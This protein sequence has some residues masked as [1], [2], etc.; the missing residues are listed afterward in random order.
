[1]L[2]TTPA[3]AGAA[4]AHA[5]QAATRPFAGFGAGAF[6]CDGGSVGSR[7]SE[8]TVVLPVPRIK[9][10][11]GSIGADAQATVFGG[12]RMSSHVGIVQEDAQKLSQTTRIYPVNPGGLGPHPAREPEPV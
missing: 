12:L 2:N 7:V 6:T 11:I 10:A 9:A 3:T 5:A 8:M 1:M 4:N